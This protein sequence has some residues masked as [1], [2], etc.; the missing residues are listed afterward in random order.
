MCQRVLLPRSR[1]DIDVDT[2]LKWG[3]RKLSGLIFLPWQGV[4]MSIVTYMLPF[5]WGFLFS[6]KS[7]YTDS[8]K[9]EQTIKAWICV[10]AFQGKE[11][12]PKKGE[13]VCYDGHARFSYQI[14]IHK[15]MKQRVKRDK[16]KTPCHGK[17]I[18]PDNFLHPHFNHLFHAFMVCSFLF[19]SVYLL[20]KE[21]RKPQ[22]KGSMYVTFWG[23]LFSLKSKYTDSNK[24]EQTIKAWNK[25]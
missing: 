15:S 24:K 13:H 20:F 4:G 1:F 19:E 10:F 14:S 16:N 8:N 21:K 25:E 17:K 9:K 2:W 5:F 6:L 22:K 18:K 7:K 11:K 23:F 3:W 12:T